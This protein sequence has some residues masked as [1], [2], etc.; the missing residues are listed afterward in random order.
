MNEAEKEV[1]KVSHFVLAMKR[2]LCRSSFKSFLSILVQ[3]FIHD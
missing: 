2:Q 3:L 1:S